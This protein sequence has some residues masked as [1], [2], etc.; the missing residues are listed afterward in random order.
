MF[1]GYSSLC[2]RV[3]FN[4]RAE[5]SMWIGG[6]GEQ[7]PPGPRLRCLPTSAMASGAPIYPAAG[8]DSHPL[9]G[10]TS[11]IFCGMC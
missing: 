7:Y 9:F 10:L 11:H 4:A 3:P 6:R 8:T 5:G 2:H 1:A